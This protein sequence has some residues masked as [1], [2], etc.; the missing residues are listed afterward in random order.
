MKKLMTIA[1]ALVVGAAFADMESSIVGYNTITAPAAG[2][3]IALAT[4]FQSATGTGALSIHD[5]VKVAN[6][7]GM[8]GLT[9]AAD[10]LWLWDSANGEWVKYFYRSTNKVWCKQGETE[11]TTDTVGPGETLF[12]RRGGGGVAT[13]ITLA[14]GVVTLTG[15]PTYPNLVAGKYAFMAYP[16]PVDMP[17]ANFKK[18]QGAP[19]GMPGLTQAA[20][21]IW[22]WDS[23]AGDWV[24]Y[25][26]RSTNKVWCKQGETTE[27]ADVVPAGEG[28]FFRRG[29][30]GVTDTVTFTFE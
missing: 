16:W 12:F 18:Y 25:F 30:G 28:F 4:Q 7:K 14:G 9:Q 10:Q 6:P 20:D 13:T 23:T 29:G 17:I 1:A 3:Y 19:K 5:L 15:N 26:Y 2:K 24:K 11:Q 21:Q 22:L 8:P 27:T